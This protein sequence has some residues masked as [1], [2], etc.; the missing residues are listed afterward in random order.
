MKFHV[1]LGK[2]VSR[3]PGNV[4]EDLTVQTARMNK[5]VIAVNVRKIISIAKNKIDAYLITGYVMVNLTVP[6]KKMNWRV[7]SI[8]FVM[9]I[10]VSSAFI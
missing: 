7:V 4:M 9:V 8:Q 6:M 10:L 2:D 5:I 3:L 1:V